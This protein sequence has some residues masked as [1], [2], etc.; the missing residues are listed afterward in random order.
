MLVVVYSN[1]GRRSLEKASYF[2]AYGLTNVK[3]ID[4]GLEAWTKEIELPG[5]LTDKTMLERSRS[6]E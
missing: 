1:Q 6:S 4:V 2:R 3:S 5:W